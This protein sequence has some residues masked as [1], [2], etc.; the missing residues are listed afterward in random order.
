MAD[1]VSRAP[2]HFAMLAPVVAGLHNSMP[3][4]EQAL[5][6]ICCAVGNVKLTRAARRAAAADQ[7]A[8]AVGTDRRVP[9]LHTLDG[10]GDTLGSPSKYI[11]S[12]T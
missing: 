4:A 12:T 5:G 10:G 6:T 3:A 1:P 8:G 11:C 2:Q 7:D 9:G